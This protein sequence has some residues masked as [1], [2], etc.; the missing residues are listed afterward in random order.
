[1]EGSACASNISQAR[2]TEHGSRIEIDLKTDTATQTISFPH[3]LAAKIVQYIQ[4]SAATAEKI[5]QL[6]QGQSIELVSPAARAWRTDRNPAEPGGG[7]NRSLDVEPMQPG[8]DAELL[9]PLLNAGNVSLLYLTRMLSD[10]SNHNRH[11]VPCIES[12]R[13][14]GGQFRLNNV[15][16]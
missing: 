1:M 3:E 15:K 13:G 16:L 11:P 4:R 5:R 12:Y 8:R 7:V 14:G 9:H 6:Q 2:A 10:A